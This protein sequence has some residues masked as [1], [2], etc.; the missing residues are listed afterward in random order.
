MKNLRLL[1]K[2][3]TKIEAKLAK[4]AELEQ[5]KQKLKKEVQNIHPSALNYF[6]YPFVKLDP[7]MIKSI[8]SQLAQ[9]YIGR[10]IVILEN[11]RTAEITNIKIKIDEKTTEDSLYLLSLAA[12]GKPELMFRQLDFIL[13]YVTFDV[14]TDN[15]DVISFNRSDFL[16]V[17]HQ[18]GQWNV[19]CLDGYIFDVQHKLFKE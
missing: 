12:A 6:E 3:Q 1:K 4:K 14:I 10:R 7:D 2:N 19:C 15:N 13:H 17:P 16:H 9:Y 8:W 11:K 5:R 18:H